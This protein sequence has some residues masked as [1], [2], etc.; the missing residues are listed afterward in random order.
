MAITLGGLLQDPDSL[1]YE[2]SLFTASAAEELAVD[3]TNKKL[4][5]TRIGNL[6]SDG[7]TL[8]CLYSK[9][10]EIWKSDADL[11]KFPFPMTPITDEQ[12]EFKEGW[13]LDD[14]INPTTKIT[15]A[16]TNSGTSAQ[17]T[18]T[19]TG[20]FN[21]S[22]VVP[23]LYVSGTGVG[24][25][26]K[27]VTVNS[28]TQITV[29]VANSGTV[30]G[31]L[32]F[33]GDVDYTY[34]LVRTG[35]WRVNNVANTVTEEWIGAISLGSLGAEVTTKTLVTT[36]TMTSTSTVTVASTAGLQAGSFVTAPGFPL[37]TTIL[38]IGGGTTFT[39]SKTIVSLASGAVVTV[40]PKDQIYYQ[41]YN[42]GASGTSLNPKNAVLT[43]QV[44]QAI[45]TYSL[46]G[47]YD[48]RDANDTLKFY[49]REQGWTY[50]SQSKTDIGVST[51]SYQTYRF[52]VTNASDALKITVA[53]SAID[54][55]NLA[56]GIPNQA[57]YSNMSITWYA[58]PQSR[59]VGGTAYNFN[60]I[61]DADTTVGPLVGGGASLEQVYQFVQWSLRRGTSVDIDQSG[62]TAKIGAITRELLKFVGDTLY[63]IY[64]SSDGGVFIDSV[65]SADKNRVVFIDNTAANVTFPFTASGSL[66]FNEYLATEGNS[67]ADAVYRL[68]YKKLYSTQGSAGVKEFGTSSAILVRKADNTTEISGTLSGNL[69]SVSFDY[70]YDNNTQSAWQPSTSYT[71]DTEFRNKNAGV[72]T[73][74]RVTTPYTSG[75]TFGATDTTNTLV[76]AGPSVVLV[77]IGL[78]KGQYV[79]QG[80]TIAKNTTNAIGAVAALERNYSNPDPGV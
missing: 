45:Q 35:G 32:T 51:L 29:S 61:V 48:Y 11:I 43:G 71:L 30:S 79:A 59:T 69:S 15:H 44:N 76:I 47:G 70:D 58:T 22:N 20:N 7:V 13:N 27:V 50:G 62:T 3:T 24:T 42:N 4:K 53:D 46:G 16:G 18:I 1:G 26:A 17:F 67:G 80:S 78:N 77:S 56:T 5:L 72:T 55:A 8:K 23:G 52:P 65:A 33:W 28:N 74:Y 40:R 38:S 39:I 73:W 25:G 66:N 49:V 2:K 21:T 75:G 12:F 14:S 6:T 68:F 36:A 10:K 63:V 34:N 60:V 41:I 54:T 64:D 37:G 9:L 31:S 19:T 57:P